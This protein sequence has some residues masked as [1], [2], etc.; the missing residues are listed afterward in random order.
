M[1][2]ALELEGLGRIPRDHLPRNRKVWHAALLQQD[3]GSR[4]DK[5]RADGPWHENETAVSKIAFRI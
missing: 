3:M 4:P 5:D 1:Q 2:G